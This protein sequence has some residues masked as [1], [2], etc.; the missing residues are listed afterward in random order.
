M[1]SVTPA[2][3]T[4]EFGVNGVKQGVDA[5][6]LVADTEVVA[7]DEHHKTHGNNTSARITNTTDKKHILENT[8]SELSTNLSDSDQSDDDEDKDPRGEPSQNYATKVKADTLTEDSY[9]IEKKGSKRLRNLISKDVLDNLSHEQC[10]KIANDVIDC[11]DSRVYHP[12]RAGQHKDEVNVPIM[13]PP[14]VEKETKYDF[15]EF[16][17]NFCR[18]LAVQFMEGHELKA[19]KFASVKTDHLLKTLSFPSN[20]IGQPECICSSQNIYDDSLSGWETPP[21]FCKSKSGK[22]RKSR[23]SSETAFSR[24]TGQLGL[25]R[26]DLFSFQHFKDPQRFIEQYR[27][28]NTVG[29]VCSQRP[30]TTKPTS[31][32]SIENDAYYNK[33]RS[34]FW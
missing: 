9:S 6:N 21:K 4:D 16:R 5:S 20:N 3:A 11:Y 1:K 31:Q 23:V 30:M 24:L 13:S 26:E 2:K 10:E 15:G 25:D 32:R 34:A 29:G 12:I 27:F 28:L 17:A 14:P 7:I 19:C 18:S 33:L 8:Q 22:K